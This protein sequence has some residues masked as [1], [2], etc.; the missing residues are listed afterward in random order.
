MNYAMLLN[1]FSALKARAEVAMP[2]PT[3]VAGGLSLSR[4]FRRWLAGR[5]VH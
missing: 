4:R 2:Y 1:D 5:P 3:K